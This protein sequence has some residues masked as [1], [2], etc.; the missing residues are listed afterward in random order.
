LKRGAKRTPTFFPTNFVVMRIARE[1]RD[2]RKTNSG[3][4]RDFA[5]ACWMRAPTQQELT[6][7]RLVARGRQYF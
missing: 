2:Q 5:G 4:R 7:E 6:G 1:S 3:S